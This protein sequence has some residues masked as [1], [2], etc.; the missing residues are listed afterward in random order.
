MNA[1]YLF[2]A[3]IGTIGLCLLGCPA[4]T[5]AQEGYPPPYY[6][7]S[8][9]LSDVTGPFLGNTTVQVPGSATTVPRAVSVW[10]SL[11][12]LLSQSLA[13][14]TGLTTGQNT[15][16][17]ATLVSSAISFNKSMDKL[18]PF[19]GCAN[20]R[21]RNYN[22]TVKSAEKLRKALANAVT[23]QR[24][25]LTSNPT[26]EQVD[27]AQKRL[28]ALEDTTFALEKATEVLKALSDALDKAR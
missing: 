15:N 1:K 26:P 22:H 11:P 23:E 25:I 3:T 4:P 5:Q 7:H 24:R 21:W 19:C 10:V 27:V 12:D 8:T 6:H 13:A 16:N 20:P 17:S 2:S 18:L 14:Q 28:K 9:N